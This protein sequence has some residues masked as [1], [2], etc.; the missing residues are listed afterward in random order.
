MGC[1]QPGIETGKRSAVVEGDRVDLID[2]TALAVL[3]GALGLGIGFD[4]Q[5]VTSNLISS[6]LVARGYSSPHCRNFVDSKS[7]ILLFSPTQP[8]WHEQS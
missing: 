6:V 8:R 2:L 1:H 7:C 5:K 4:L 3:G